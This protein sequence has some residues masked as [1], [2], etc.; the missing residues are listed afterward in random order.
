MMDEPAFKLLRKGLANH[1]HGRFI[2]KKGDRCATVTIRGL[3]ILDS[4]KLLDQL[5][6]WLK[7]MNSEINA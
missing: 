6:E 1:L 7:L 2:Y 4:D 3:G 5:T